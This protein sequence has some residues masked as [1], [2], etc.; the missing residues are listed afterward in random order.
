[1]LQKYKKS[2]RHSGKLTQA[3]F[4]EVAKAEDAAKNEGRHLIVSG[5]LRILGVSR[6]GYYSFKRKNSLT[7]N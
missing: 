3:Y 7:Q 1:M 2:N 4:I 6:N 5:V